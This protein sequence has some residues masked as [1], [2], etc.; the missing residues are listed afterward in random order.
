MSVHMVGAV[1]RIVFENEDGCVIPVRTMGDGIDH[2]AYSQVVI[3][4]RGCW[5]RVVGLG[6]A[7]V[8][9]TQAQQNILRKLSSFVLLTRLHERVEFVHELVHTKLIGEV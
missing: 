4:Y 9:I 6:A 5:C 8:V 3:R 2:A 1:L 7:G